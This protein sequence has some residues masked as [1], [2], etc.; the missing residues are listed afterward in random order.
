MDAW[1]LK[2]GANFT[3]GENTNRKYDIQVIIC[4]YKYSIKSGVDAWW[5]K[6]GA[7]LTLGE[8]T[9]RKYDIQVPCATT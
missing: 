2:D 9:N 6:D 3:L 4:W 1:W 5:R 7:N 8:N